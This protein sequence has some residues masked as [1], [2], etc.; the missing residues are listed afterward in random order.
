ML[1]S[2]QLVGSAFLIRFETNHKDFGKE[3]VTANVVD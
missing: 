3:E 2:Y 1:L